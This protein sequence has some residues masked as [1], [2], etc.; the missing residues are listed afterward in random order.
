MTKTEASKKVLE[1][2][3]ERKGFDW[4]FEEIDSQTK[5]EIKRKLGTLLKNLSKEG[6]D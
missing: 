1:F 4:W 6:I 5:A 3:S 2:L